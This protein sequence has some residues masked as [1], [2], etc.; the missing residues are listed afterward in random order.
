MSSSKKYK[1]SNQFDPIKC[2]IH[3]NSSLNQICVQ[4][5]C[6]LQFQPNC[7]ICQYD[8]KNACNQHFVMPIQV[9][10]SKLESLIQEEAILNPL[11]NVCSDE[12]SLLAKQFKNLGN[13]CLE[14]SENIEMSASKHK[15]TFLSLAPEIKAVENI[16]KNVK[17]DDCTQNIRLNL[18]QL[19]EY[20]QIQSDGNINFQFRNNER[21]ERLQLRYYQY[22]SKLEQLCSYIINDLNTAYSNSIFYTGV[23]F[24]SNPSSDKKSD[25]STRNSCVDQ[26]IERMRA[27]LDSPQKVGMKLNDE[28]YFKVKTIEKGDQKTFPIFKQKVKINYKVYDEDFNLLDQNKEGKPFIFTIGIGEVIKGWELAIP[29]M[30]LGE[31]SLIICH[32][33]LINNSKYINIFQNEL[34]SSQSLYFEIEIIDII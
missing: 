27:V 25:Y 19:R 11:N 16:I 15:K 5:G 14:I 21:I 2:Q 28:S 24:G 12:I 7:P 29:E 20:L 23:Q 8:K 30:C 18:M 3:K 33:N 4:D 31:K 1:I 10:L 34:S 22:Y 26:Q 9:F 17:E 13:K 6:I 32:K